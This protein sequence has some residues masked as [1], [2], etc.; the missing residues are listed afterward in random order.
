[1]EKLNLPRI[2]KD[3]S[4]RRRPVDM[5]RIVAFVVENL[6]SIGFNAERRRRRRSRPRTVPFRLHRPAGRGARS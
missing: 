1:M 2:T 3:I 6:E 4:R 5:D